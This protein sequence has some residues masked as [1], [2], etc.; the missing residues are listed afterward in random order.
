[1][2]NTIMTAKNTFGEGLIMD[3][4]P[5]NTQS[6]VLTSALNATLLTFN[7]N[8]MSLQ[9]DM[10]NGR[11][12]TARLPDGY[13]P[14]GTCE[15]G[16]IIYIVSYN[17]ILN[18][19]QIGCFPSP[20][21][22]IS[23]TE[24]GN[25]GTIISSQD[26]QVIQEG[27][28]TGELVA[29]TKKYIL[30]EKALN[31]G[32]KYIIYND[33]SDSIESNIKQLSDL[34][35]ESHVFGTLPRFLKLH[36]VSIEDSGKITYLDNTVKWYNNKGDLHYFIQDCL[37]SNYGNAT[38]KVDLDSYRSLVSSAYSI[39]QSKISGKLAILAELEK[40]N[41]FN[42]TYGI[43]SKGTNLENNTELKDY[44]IFLE[45]NWSSDNLNINPQYLV[46]TASDWN[47]NTVQVYDKNGE[48]LLNQPYTIKNPPRY[49]ISS[50]QSYWNTEITNCSEYWKSNTFEEYYKKCYTTEEAKYKSEHPKIIRV[51]N[52]VDAIGIPKEGEYL[53]I[54]NK[55]IKCDNNQNYFYYNEK[56]EK[57]PIAPEKYYDTLIN[58]YFHYGVI[59]H[60]W[61]VTI[62]GK[63][64]KKGEVQNGKKAPDE[65]YQYNKKDL[66]Y[67]YQITPAMPYG[68][69]SE[70]AIDGYIDFSKIGSGIIELLK[71]KYYNTANTTTLTFGFDVYPEP[72]KGVSEIVLEFYDNQGFAAA[73]HISGRK[74]YSGTFTETIPLNGSTGSYK[75]NA[76]MA[77]GKNDNIHIGL[78]VS[79]ADYNANP[80]M[81]VFSDGSKDGIPEGYYTNDSITS[82]YMKLAANNFESVFFTYRIMKEDLCCKVF[83]AII[84]CAIFVLVAMLGLQNIFILLI[85]I[86]LPITIIVGSVRFAITESRV[87]EIYLE[88]RKLFEKKDSIRH[89]DILNQLINYTA[90]LTAGN[91][92]L[93]DRTYNKLNASL[94]EEWEKIKNEFGIK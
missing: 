5:D 54:T 19:S 13:V 51:L 18:K 80:N 87:K 67:H 53:P 28:P 90:T 8:E 14:V 42:C 52:N 4:A 11:V 75:L 50:S 49:Y 92:L 9:N 20:E 27:S 70:Y 25:T 46:L 65:I 15:F 21:R 16:D 64:I 72:N 86:T 73:Y 61:D 66:I 94:S 40:I 29:N 10:G 30:Y 63:Y 45:C 38:G 3:F 71:W 77:N 91:V 43:Y 1:M 85:Q 39:F 2:A 83:K 76:V 41:G 78:P 48:V 57:V 24:L 32:D 55:G 7:G 31:P 69:L 58:N 82:G 88:Y 84:I 81:Y 6:N 37:N 26:F 62:P 68:L 89:A 23:S 17:P 33:G 59:K 35:N 12:E 74:S 60:F 34:H 22:N 47:K 36:V 93:S 44:S 79:E 56:G